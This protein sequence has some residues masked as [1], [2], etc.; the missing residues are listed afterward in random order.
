MLSPDQ[1]YPLV[2]AWVRA[3][4]NVPQA[5][6]CAAVAQLLTALLLGQSLH[7][8]VLQRTLASPTPVPARQRYKRVARAFDRPWLAS[9][10]LTPGLVRAAVALVA[11]DPAGTPTAGVTHLALDGVRCGR[12][13][14]LVLGVVWHGRVLPVG[15]AV[16]P[17]PWPKGRFTPAAC[18]LVRQV[19]A[20]WPANRPAHLVADRG[21]PSRPLFQA[22]QRAGWGWTLRLGARSL[23]TVAG[24]EHW[25]MDLL[26]DARVGRWQVYPA[27]TYGSAAPTI[28]GH[29][30][31]GRGLPVLPAHQANPSGLR[32]RAQ[33]QAR[34]Q[35]ALHRKHRAARG[36][37][38][39]AATTDAW[40]VL[41]TTHPDRRAALAS[42]RRRWGIEGSFRD[43]QGGWDGRHG[44]ELDHTIVRTGT[45]ARVERLVG[46]WALGVLVQ[47][48]VGHALTQPA[49]P[50]L[51]HAVLAQWTTT[52]RLSVWARGRFALTEP[53]GR[54][55]PWLA[56][57]LRAGAHQ[58]AAATAP[59]T[60]LVTW[61]DHPPADVP[62]AA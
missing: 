15:W 48:W 23:V 18:A 12:W 17:Y 20:T 8:S 58:V 54:L 2:A 43:A 53:S 45:A 24:H 11:P 5:T 3:V 30:V 6:A 13:E 39:A 27:A 22:L 35:A 46:L 51:A 10:P 44:W 49:A 55:A 28:P 19:A 52:G 9:A 33:Q 7:A 25:V 38:G 34:R 60:P 57:T 37:A 47:S 1:V 62:R 36:T 40:V 59:P 56:A 31:V 26:A 41:F 21:F 14:L 50:S 16:L 32:Q 61:S 42:Y 29:L 4:A